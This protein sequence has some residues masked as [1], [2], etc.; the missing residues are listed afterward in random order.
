MITLIT[1]TFFRVVLLASC[2][3][4]VGTPTDPHNADPVASNIIFQSTD[5]GKTW[6]DISESLPVYQQ[7]EDFFAGPSEIYL[8]VGGAMYSSK[9]NLKT[10]LWHKV[11]SLDP[12]AGSIAFNHSGVMAYNYEGEIYQNISPDTWLPRFTRFQK[13]SMR[14]IF[15]TSEGT[16]FVGF[17]SG[18][19]KSVDKGKSW[20]QVQN[21]GWVMQ[22][23]ESAGVLVAAGQKGIMRSIDNGENWQWVINEGGVG[24]AVEW[25]NGGF[26]AIA[27]N[28]TTQV[29]GI[30]VSLDNGKTWN[31]I[32]EGL[33]PSMFISSVKQVGNVLLC[34][35]PDGIYQSADMGKTWTLVHRLTEKK[36][37]KYGK[38]WSVVD[39]AVDKKVLKLFVSGDVVY[40]I[41]RDLGC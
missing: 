40:A 27:F 7:P 15:E 33:P 41:A 13:R 24:I 29:R 10:P 39:S 16:I 14:T 9:N 38:T 37:V 11:E 31:A 1:L 25:I 20:K 35:H 4:F 5:G 6:D 30:H 18:L 23:V 3:G 28:T 21:E 17:D 36:V 2:F 34:G 32:N 8:R 12:E 22:I 26:A 19:F